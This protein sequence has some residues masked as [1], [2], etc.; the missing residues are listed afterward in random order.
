M[1]T[2]T[3]TTIVLTAALIAGGFAAQSLQAQETTPTTT[4]ELTQ[5]VAEEMTFADLLAVPVSFA[6]AS[7]IAQGT[8]EGRLI[9]LS[10]ED[11]EDAPVYFA[12]IGSATS[13]SELMI[14]A[15]DGTVM[16][17]FT[18]SADTPALLQ[19]LMDDDLDDLD[20]FAALMDDYDDG[21]DCEHDHD[22]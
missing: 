7:E 13:V 14:D 17:T 10:L 4:G 20:E 2:R 6:Q 12:V 1:I 11:F 22:S 19:K 5:A 15:N 9:E 21:D 18:Q 16:S 3:T 8:A